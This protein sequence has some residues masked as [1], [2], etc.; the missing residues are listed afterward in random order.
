MVKRHAV[1]RLIKHILRRRTQ[2]PEQARD[3]VQVALHLLLR[4]AD[5][6]D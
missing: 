6:G 4:R 3:L 2:R 5:A 1:L